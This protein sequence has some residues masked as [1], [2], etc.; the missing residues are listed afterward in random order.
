MVFSIRVR[1]LMIAAV[2]GVI[3]LYLVVKS[4]NNYILE[5]L[6]IDENEEEIGVVTEPPVTSATPPVVTTE[7]V[8]KP[9]VTSATAPIVTT[10]PVA[11]HTLRRYIVCSSYWE[12]QS[13]A[14]IN[15]FCLQRWANSIGLTAV[16]PFVCQSELKFPLEILQNNT[17]M[18]HTLRLRD[19]I[20]L[21]HWIAE[22][23]QS[24]VPPLET[25]ENFVLYSPKKVVLVI[26]PYGGV[27]GTY[28]NNE[29]SKHPQ[30]QEKLTEFFD[31]HGKLF[32]LLQLEVVHKVC[33]TFDHTIPT[34]TFNRALQ[35]EDMK[36]VTVWISEWQGVE[37]GRVAFTGLGNN[38]FGRLYGGKAKYM[39]MIKP[40]SRILSDSKR[41]VHD[42]LGVDFYQYDAVISRNKPLDFSRL[43]WYL[44]HFEGCASQL[45]RYTKSVKSKMF[46]AI[47]MGRFGDMVR[48][49]K[50][51][52][53]PQGKYTGR[54]TRL[55]EHYLNIVYGN[56]SIESY[57]NEFVKVTNGIVDSGYIGSLQRTI[58][59]HAEH[60]FV[61][62]GH[63]SFQ[64]VLI[65]HFS[66]RNALT[67]I[68]Y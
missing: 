53:D 6:S 12:Q 52:Y 59:L 51:D 11:D 68:C 14:M 60:V 13:N 48:A 50:F 2:V 8:T 41:Y 45:E 67:T 18:A 3:L 32:R 43:Q 24:G 23:K 4:K 42:V 27:E 9:P 37:N 16:E 17:I 57:E 21:D 31:K 66:K 7:A 33:I 56:K 44:E 61:V 40:S 25:W 39:R 49:E 26:L 54:G 62:G 55:Y 46:L 1:F 64:D 34:E 65:E 36:E 5:K 58:A 19:Y 22:G 47:D 35:I 28:T 30:C 38:K 10:K 29:I 63:S 15:L 20:D